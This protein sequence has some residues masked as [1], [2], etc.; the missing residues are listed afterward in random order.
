M[1]LR[2]LSVLV[3]AV[4]AA[5]AAMADDGSFKPPSSFWGAAQEEE[6]Q[7]PPHRPRAFR[8]RV[9]RYYSVQNC[10]PQHSFETV[11]VFENT[12]DK[13]IG[14]ASKSNL[15]AMLVKRGDL[16]AGRGTRFSDAD[17]A[18]TVV[19]QYRAWKPSPATTAPVTGR[20]QIT[21]VQ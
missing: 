7:S 16:R 20:P 15:A 10:P 3:I 9:Y 13:E 4:T 19:E 17:R 21:P 18:A 6:A 2:C 5:N 11:G 1:K 8:H 12:P 14:C